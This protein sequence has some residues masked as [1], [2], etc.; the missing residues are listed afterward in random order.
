MSMPLFFL[1]LYDREAA[2]ILNTYANTAL[3]DADI[4]FPLRCIMRSAV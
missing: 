3:S 2:V 1:C 4:S